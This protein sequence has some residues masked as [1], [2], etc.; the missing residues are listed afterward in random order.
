MIHI[1]DE[2]ALELIGQYAP[3][4]HAFLLD[5][6]RPSLATPE[7]GGTGRTHDWSVSAKFVQL[8]PRPVFLAGGL[9]PGN[10][11]EAIRVVRPFGVDLCS[12]VRTDNQ[13]DHVKLEEFISAV[14]KA[15]EELCL[16]SES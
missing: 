11:K 8:S 9:S 7:Y 2:R 3:Y 14:Q 12:G 4:V 5:S 13:L 10:V 16:G 6:G 15:D 1:E